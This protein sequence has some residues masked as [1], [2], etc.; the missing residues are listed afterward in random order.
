MKLN[1]NS[2]Y[3]V[4]NLAQSQDIITLPIGGGME[5]TG[6][7]RT[8]AAQILRTLS[9]TVSSTGQTIAATSSLVRYTDTG[10]GH[11]ITLPAIVDGQEITILNENTSLITVHCQSGD[12]IATGTTHTISSGRFDKFL[13]LGSR[14]FCI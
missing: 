10:V 9:E 13:G 4:R 7:I 12:N 5:L 1:G 6:S 14:W 8:G 2:D 11:T 3:V